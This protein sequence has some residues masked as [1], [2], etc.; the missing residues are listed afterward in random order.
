M[1]LDSFVPEPER[2]CSIELDKYAESQEMSH[3]HRYLLIS[4]NQGT[5]YRGARMLSTV[6]KV[7]KKAQ[8]KD[9]NKPT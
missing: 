3:I 1:H 9:G 7:T 4:K 5:R 8:S 6:K 2:G